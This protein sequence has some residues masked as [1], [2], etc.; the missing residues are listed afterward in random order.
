[1]T[2][3]IKLSRQ[4]KPRDISLNFEE[5]LKENFHVF[6][7]TNKLNIN[8]NNLMENDYFGKEKSMLN[9]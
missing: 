9:V 5:N 3:V 8:T 7:V 6:K 1:M 4:N 2:F